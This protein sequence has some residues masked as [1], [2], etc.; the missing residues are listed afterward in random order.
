MRPPPHSAEKSAAVAEPTGSEVTCVPNILRVTFEKGE[1]MRYM[2]HLDVLR[3]F[4]RGMRRADIP[5]KFSEGF[6]PHAVLTFALPLGVGT[7]SECEIADVSIGGEIGEADFVSKMNSALPKDGI[8]VIKATYTDQKMPEIVK[9]IYEIEFENKTPF[10]AQKI[11]EAIKGGNIPV[12][13]KS[14]RQEKEVNLAEHIFSYETRQ[15]DERRFVLDVKI[16]AGGKF[17]VRPQ[18]LAE[19]LRG[20]CDGFDPI[21]TLPCRKKFIFENEEE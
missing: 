2:G 4:V 7:T 13:K 1:A 11:E 10:S 16:S 6:N 15:I 9:A 5:F 20:V 19:G 21:L 8:K 14:K 17:N 18:L 12:M 3:T